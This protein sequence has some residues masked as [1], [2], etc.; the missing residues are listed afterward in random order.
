MAIL[1]TTDIT[2]IKVH[3]VYGKLSKGR[4]MIQHVIVVFQKKAT[5]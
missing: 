2:I 4:H 3:R 5:S 1:A